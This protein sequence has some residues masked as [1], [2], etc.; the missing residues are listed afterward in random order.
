ML[1]ANP[2]VATR[3]NY[4]SRGIPEAQVTNQ[5]YYVVVDPAFTNSAAKA[6]L[7]LPI[8]PGTDAELLACI[9]CFILV[10]DNPESKTFS[11]IDYLFIK[12]IQ[13]V[14]KNLNRIFSTRVDCR[15]KQTD[16]YIFRQSGEKKKQV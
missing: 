7:W 16:F 14:G 2:L 5:M 4:M 10:H 8:T 15:I 1:G 13:K 12:I 3:F 9:L 6:N 11:Y